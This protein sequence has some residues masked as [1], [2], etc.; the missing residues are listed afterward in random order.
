MK[1][2]KKETFEQSQKEVTDQRLFNLMCDVCETVAKAQPVDAYVYRRMADEPYHCAGF[3]VS[4][5]IG[6][7]V[8]DHLGLFDVETVAYAL[9]LFGGLADYRLPLMTMDENKEEPEATP[10]KDDN[11]AHDGVG[12]SA[13]EP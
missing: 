1:E 11:A 3:P 5:M 13:D 4:L 6:T 2:K 10:D 7:L 8:W 12:E 9:R